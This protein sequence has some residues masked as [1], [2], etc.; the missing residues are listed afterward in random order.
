MITVGSKTVNDIKY[1]NTQI[2]RV[3]KGS[4]LVWE[5]VAIGTVLLDSANVGS[6]SIE[7]KV[8][9]LYEI[10]AVGG[11]GGSAGSGGGGKNDTS[12]NNPVNPINGA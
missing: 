12:N 6:Y 1:G 9:G 11:G 4:Q 10:I 8:P 2:L 7:I 3:Y 5:R